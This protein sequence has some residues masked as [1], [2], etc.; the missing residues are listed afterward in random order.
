MINKMITQLVERDINDLNKMK[1]D[2]L[3]SF[4]KSLLTDYYYELDNDTIKEYYN[5]L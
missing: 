1:K 5:E 2:Q 3:L 4:C